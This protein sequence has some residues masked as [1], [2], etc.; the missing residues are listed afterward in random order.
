MDSKAIKEELIAELSKQAQNGVFRA[1]RHDGL[2]YR[3]WQG[4]TISL[5]DAI[6]V[7]KQVLDDEN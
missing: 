2:H 4:P 1:E 7:V 5:D 6:A 3:D